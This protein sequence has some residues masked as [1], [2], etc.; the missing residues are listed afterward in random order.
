MC[1]FTDA[2]TSVARTRIFARRIG[3]EQVLVYQMQ[4]DALGELAM[5]LPIP[6]G[7][8][9]D[10]FPTT[11]TVDDDPTAR[12]RPRRVISREPAERDT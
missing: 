1:M 5:V 2:V 10:E 8:E 7:T 9:S 6:E 11:A 12:D 4:F 3:A